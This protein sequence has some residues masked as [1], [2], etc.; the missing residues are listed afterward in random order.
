MADKHKEQKDR[1]REPDAE[2]SESH[3]EHDP[4]IFSILG[5]V[6]EHHVPGIAFINDTGEPGVDAVNDITQAHGE[7]LGEMSKLV[8]KNA[9]ELAHVETADE[10]DANDQ[11]QIVGEQTPEAAMKTG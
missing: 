7:A 10:R 2:A 5:P 3:H 9:G 8:G 6:L 4:S 1:S 11:N